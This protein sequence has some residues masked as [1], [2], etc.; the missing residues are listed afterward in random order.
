MYPAACSVWYT[1]W[2]VYTPGTLL[3][4][5]CTLHYTA[6]TLHFGLGTQTQPSSIMAD[7]RTGQGDL[8]SISQHLESYQHMARG[9]SLQQTTTKGPQLP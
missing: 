8:T 2:A 5:Q 7:P 6:G 4:L 1:A 9:Q 3:E